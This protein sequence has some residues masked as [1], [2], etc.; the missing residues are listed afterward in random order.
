MKLLNFVK[1]TSV[2]LCLSA[3]ADLAPRQVNAPVYSVENMVCSTNGL[4]VPV[5]QNMARIVDQG[6]LD[7]F[8]SLENVR[9]QKI[10]AVFSPKNQFEKDDFFDGLTCY[11][12]ISVFDSLK[13]IKLSDG[14]FKKLCAVWDKE[15]SQ[16]ENGLDVTESFM[17]DEIRLAIKN[18]KIAKDDYKIFITIVKLNSNENE[19]RV[20]LKRSETL[21]VKGQSAIKSDTLLSSIF[22]KVNTRCVITK[23]CQVVEDGKDLDEALRKMTEVHDD[24]ASRI[25][26]SNKSIVGANQ[27]GKTMI[28]VIYGFVILFA[29]IIGRRRNTPSELTSVESIVDAEEPKGP[30]GIWGWNT[31]PL[32]NLAG[33]VIM[34]VIQFFKLYLPLIE[35]GAMQNCISG[36]GNGILNQQEALCVFLESV[37]TILIAVFAIRVI[38]LAFARRR[39]YPKAC[40]WLFVMNALLSII[41]LVFAAHLGYSAEGGDVKTAVRGLMF[42]IIW[43]MYFAKSERIKN[44]FTR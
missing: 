3:S 12:V 11:G 16:Y 1:L 10:L 4:T 21:K 30:V 37:G 44:T 6:L 28:Y 32:L 9:G 38:E 36:W 33:I 41:G 34:T 22:M 35:N 14:D 8:Y 40:T 7:K 23:L 29:L 31:I 20:I 17:T 18:G 15:F 5:P 19:Y 43:G 2:M 27:Y 25:R 26:E 24:W 39:L 13:N 42:A